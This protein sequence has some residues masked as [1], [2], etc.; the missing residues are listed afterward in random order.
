[1]EILKSGANIAALIVAVAMA[2]TL[3]APKAQTAKIAGTLGSVF[4]G[5]IREAKA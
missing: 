4:T 1:V 2:A 5:A 3:V